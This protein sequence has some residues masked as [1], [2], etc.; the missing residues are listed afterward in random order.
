MNNEISI[1]NEIIENKIYL[2]REQKVMLDNDLAELYRE[3]FK[4][5]KQSRKYYNKF[6]IAAKVRNLDDSVYKADTELA[7]VDINEAVATKNKMLLTE[8]INKLEE[9]TDEENKKY[10]FYPYAKS[11]LENAKKTSESLITQ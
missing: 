11:R 4:D 6:R 2:I 8:A 7:L 9:L 10:P 5:Y 3:R 1:P